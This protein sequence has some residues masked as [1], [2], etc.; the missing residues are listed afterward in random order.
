MMSPTYSEVKRILHET[1]KRLSL[2][3]SPVSKVIDAI[4]DDLKRIEEHEE[5]YSKAFPFIDFDQERFTP[6]EKEFLNLSEISLGIL[7]IN[8]P[9]EFYL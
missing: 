1:L 7:Q 6:S 5:W 3:Y 9:Y 2:F 8:E 4:E